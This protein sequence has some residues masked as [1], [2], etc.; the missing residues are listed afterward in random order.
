MLNDAKWM[1]AHMAKRAEKQQMKQQ[2]L[3]VGRGEPAPV[4]SAA[5]PVQPLKPV[6]W[7]KLQK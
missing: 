7:L 2:S 6:P 5:R 4:V 3:A 1:Q